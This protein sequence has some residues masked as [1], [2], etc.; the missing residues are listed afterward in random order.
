MSDADLILSSGPVRLR[1]MNDAR[2]EH[3]A[4][5]WYNDLEPRY[6]A[7]VLSR[8]D[9]VRNSIESGRPTVALGV[10]KESKV[11]L[12]EFR[13]TLPGGTPPHLR[14]FVIRRGLTLWAATGITKKS[15]KIKGQDW[16]EAERL[17]VGWVASHSA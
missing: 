15:N 6:Q 5:Q 13:V 14:M 11:G 8:L 9:N 7:R 1:A 16:R 4:K 17:A 12:L 3:P 10:M 2:G